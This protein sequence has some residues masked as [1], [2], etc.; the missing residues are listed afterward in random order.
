MKITPPP[1]AAEQSRVCE[2]R[3]GVLTI[4]S[5]SAPVFRPKDKAKVPET[6]FF[7]IDQVSRGGTG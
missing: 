5:T 2:V 7:D 6:L 1:A 4:G 3:D